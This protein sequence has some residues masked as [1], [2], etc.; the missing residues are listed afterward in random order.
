MSNRRPPNAPTYQA[1][2]EPPHTIPV[3]TAWGLLGY[4]DPAGLTLLCRK[5]GQRQIVDLKALIRGERR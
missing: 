4:L 2:P 5:A 1:A 3:R